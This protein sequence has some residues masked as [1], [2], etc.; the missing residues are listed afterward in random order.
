MRCWSLLLL[1]SAAPALS[2]E[3]PPTEAPPAEAPAAEAP[4]SES[5][6]PSR[7]RSR[8][9]SEA[10]APAPTPTPT[11][12]PAPAPAEEVPEPRPTSRTGSEPERIRK[13]A[14]AL[15]D[16]LLAGD[17]RGSVGYLAFP[18]QLEERR[19][20]APESLVATWVKELRNKRTDLVT[21]YDIEVLPYAELERKYGKPP[22]RLG[23][24]IPRGTEVYAAVANLSGHAAVILYRQTDDGWKAFAYTD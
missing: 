3:N 2:Q 4:A 23:A 16:S 24:V 5:P 6:R 21:L 14:H 15:V 22:A 19:F 7:R 11:P 17:V 9:R 18:F 13:E 10:P 8:T 12:A 20:D 1:L